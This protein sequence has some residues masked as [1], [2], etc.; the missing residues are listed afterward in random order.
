MGELGRGGGGREGE[1]R[2]KTGEEGEGLLGLAGRRRACSTLGRKGPALRVLGC[3]VQGEVQRAC[4]PS[5]ETGGPWAGPA[6]HG[7]RSRG[8]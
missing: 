4:V 2:E 5:T 6:S 3:R 1:R 8:R 7:V